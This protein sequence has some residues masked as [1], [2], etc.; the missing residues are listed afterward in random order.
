MKKLDFLGFKLK[1]WMDI[2]SSDM[3]IFVCMYIYI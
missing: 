2:V 3:Y 1:S